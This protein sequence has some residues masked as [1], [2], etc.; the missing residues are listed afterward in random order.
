MSVIR[1]AQSAIDL[2]CAD[3]AAVVAMVTP[4]RTAQLLGTTPREI[5][6]RI[7][8]GELHFAESESGLLLVCLNSLNRAPGT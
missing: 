2:W 5:Y 6:R 3:C 7:E 1:S 8:N 4:E